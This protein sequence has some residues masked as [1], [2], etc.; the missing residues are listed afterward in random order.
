MPTARDHLRLEAVGGALYAISGRKDDLRHNYDAVERYDI[1]TDTWTT[2]APIPRGRGGFGSVVVDGRIYTFG[3]ESVWTCYDSIER[4]DP[5]AD[6]WDDVGP[7]PEARHGIMAGVIDGRIHLV[8]G[9]RHPRV[10][11]SGIHR[12]L[13]LAG[14]ER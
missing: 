8:S 1:A 12:V 4:Y 14:R 10:S 3:G 9:G 6:H 7:L 5:E 2:V 11:I 13:E